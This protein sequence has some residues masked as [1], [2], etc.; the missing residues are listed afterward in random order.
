MTP[1]RSP[2]RP[3]SWLVGLAFAVS[4]CTSLVLE[5]VWSKA[6]ALLLGSTLHAVSTVVAAYLF[7]LAL[8]AW[9]AGRRAAGVARPL[10]LYGFLEMGVGA[11]ALVSLFLIHAMDPI[12]GA[13]Y[14]RLGATSPAYLVARVVLAGAVLLVPTVLMGATLPTL[15]AW[16]SRERTGWERGL[17]L[18]YGLNTLGAVVGAALAGAVLVPGLGLR[19]TTWTVGALALAVGAWMA[20]LGSKPPKPQ[21]AP[22]H[23]PRAPAHAPAAAPHAPAH[24][25]HAA[26]PAILFGLSGAV[27][28]VFE[29]TWARVFGLV[30][31][32]SVYSFAL[33]LATYLLGLALGSLLLGGRLAAARDPWRAFGLL[34]AG[35]AAGAALGLWLLPSLPKLFLTALFAERAHVGA[36]YGLLA[37]IAASI[38]LLPCVAFGALFPVGVRLVAGN[39][40]NGAR[41]TGLAYAANT[42]GTLTGSLLA[43]F[44]LLPTIGVHATWVGASLVALAIGAAALVRTQRP[45]AALSAMALIALATALAPAWSKALF[46]LGSYRAA[47]LL[48][49]GI[50]TGSAAIADL[51]RKESA[52][53]LVFYREGLHGVVSVHETPG[54]PP[55]LS[56]RVNGKS[57]ASTGGDMATQVFLGHIP[58]LFAPPHASVCVIG[59]GSGVTARAALEHAPRRLT[60]VELE[61]AVLQASRLFD[62]WSDTVLAD[63]RVEIVVEDGRQH[64]QH[65][66]RTYDVIISEPSNPW[67]AGVNN[68]FTVDFYRRVRTALA[69]RG[70]FCQWIQAY[71]ISPAAL[72]SLFRSFAQVFPNAEV[73]LVNFDFVIVAPPPGAKVPAASLF[74][75]NENNAVADYLRRF[76]LDGNGTVAGAHLTGLATLVQSFP[77]VPLNTDDR[78]YVEYRAPIDL[79]EPPSLQD[80]WSTVASSP[81]ADLGRWVRAEEVDSVAYR[82]GLYDCRMARWKRAD[83]VAREL[84]T[85]GAEGEKLADQV[86]ALMTRGLQVA[87][88]ATLVDEAAKAL[89][90]GDTPALKNDLSRALALDP[91]HPAANLLAAR[92]ATQAGALDQARRYLAVAL[93]AESPLERSAAFVNLGLIEMREGHAAAGR[94]AFES[95]RAA[96]PSEAE[97]YVYLSRWQQ[98][99]GHPDSARAVLEQGLAQARAKQPIQSEM[100]RLGAR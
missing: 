85:Q 74:L 94:A 19:A 79:Y 35:V 67:V 45:W 28:L 97:P 44:V 11:Y 90:A 84:R 26:V 46:T 30:F 15:V 39:Q 42:A 14:A 49:S 80:L 34:Q 70:V 40:A 17:G 53:Q 21:H 33:V 60:V 61:P 38:T 41:A 63:P 72:G 22:A 96:A 16:V 27:A 77:A 59:Q 8:G 75:E 10:R 57:D 98:A 66:G 13:L 47:V 51:G 55:E 24:A 68:L 71:E 20:A 29:I 4:G 48:H 91:E 95:A 73:F 76:H 52:N 31:G 3:P 62:A 82:A 64:L 56:L 92:L 100:G 58:M 2:N 78:P 18:L 88:V 69:P 99:A 86:S 32:S 37:A 36:L 1:P 12:A 54:D 93:R 43:G 5:V 25:P 65:A 23:T 87:Q 89:A 7:G 9:L 81:L 50:T 83:A 6:L